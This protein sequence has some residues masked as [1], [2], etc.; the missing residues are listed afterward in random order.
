MRRVLRVRQVQREPRARQVPPGV[1]AM[2]TP[3]E[4]LA[5]WVGTARAHV[6]LNRIYGLSLLTCGKLYLPFVYLIL[7]SVL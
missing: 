1:T 7:P 2:I 4:Q 5:A 6:S 3:T